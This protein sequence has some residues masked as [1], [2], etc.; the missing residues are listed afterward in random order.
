ME[1]SGITPITATQAMSQSQSLW[2]A[3]R[4]QQQQTL[5]ALG[6]ALQSG[7]LSDAQAAFQTLTQ[8]SSTPSSAASATGTPQTAVAKDLTALGT[9][10]SSGGLTDAQEAYKTLLQDIQ[11]MQ[12]KQGAHKHH[13][14]HHQTQP[15]DA[16]SGGIATAIS[17]GAAGSAGTT[18]NT[19]A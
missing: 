17:P 7:N 10:L 19:T 6:T 11:S 18:I 3:R 16:S 2:E 13:H 14:H 5:Q 12:Q 8:N 15:V 4:E 1:T 9:A